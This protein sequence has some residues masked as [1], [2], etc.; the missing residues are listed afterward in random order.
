[1]NIAACRKPRPAHGAA[2]PIRW[3]TTALALL[4]ALLALGAP[5]HAAAAGA[6]AAERLHAL[7]KDSWQKE[8][9]ADPLAANYLG[10]N[11]YNDRWPD[12]SAAGIASRQQ[13]DRDTLAALRAIAR[14][15]LESAD[16]LNY[17]LFA[18]EYEQ[19][20]AT[21]PFKPWLYQINH[22]GGIQTLSEVTE[23]LSF[24]TVKDYE[25]W[26][27]RLDKLGTLVDQHIALLDQAVREK[28]TQP[29]AIMQRVPPQLALQTVA[30]AEQSPFYAPFKRFP[31]S[32]DAANQARLAAAGR[33]AIERTVLPAYARLSKAFNER[34]L[35]AT[36]ETVGIND[37]PDGAAFYRERI[38]F[39]TTSSALT[40]DQIHAIG[41]AEVARIRGEM[42]KIKDQVGF[43]GSLQ[44]FFVFLRTDPQFYYKSGQELFEGYLAVSKRID[45]NLVRLFGTLPRTPYGVRA[46]PATSAPNTTTA[47]YQGPAADGTRPGYY[48]VNLY[49]PEVRPKYE[50]EVLSVHEAVPGH[51][52]QIALAMEQAGMPDFRRN[53]GY[54]AYIEGWA[55]Y[56]ESLGEE[57]GLYK[58]PYSKFGQLTY[59]MWRAVRLVV[60]TGMHAKGWS[61]QQA[62][63]FFKDNAAKTEADIVN[64]IDRYISWPGQALAYKIGQLR[65]QGL[66]AEAMRELGPRFDLRRFHDALL[67]SGAVPL[68]LMEQRMRSW[69]AARKAE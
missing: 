59:D 13:H 57:L 36:R 39:H 45:P 35:P 25:D 14:D 11:R 7:F 40:A 9:A 58:D 63:D 18:R 53:A 42:L 8:L 17:D 19:R 6:G 61:R 27:A 31:E 56:S 32:I 30:N 24:S 4:G 66:R 16:Q 3:R 67:G 46:I 65:I 1:M 21:A 44:E 5:S 20:I 22:Q 55:L 38:A 62:I 47:Y 15:E 2:H 12:L 52:L 34:Y 10:D 54:T 50:M 28:R 41:L 68:D 60:D 43:K 29:R 33:A 69:I 26:I 37:T 64:E 48:Y 23:L 49:R 51:H